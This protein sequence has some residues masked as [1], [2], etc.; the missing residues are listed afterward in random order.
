MAHDV[1][2]KGK[3]YFQLDIYQFTDLSNSEAVKYSM[4]KGKDEEFVHCAHKYRE[5][6]D[7][8]TN[9]VQPW[10]MIVGIAVLLVVGCVGPP[11]Y[12]RIRASVASSKVDDEENAKSDNV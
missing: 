5:G 4:A 9:K 3:T 10:M 6:C 2:T 11:I 8:D 12:K 7:V 1:I